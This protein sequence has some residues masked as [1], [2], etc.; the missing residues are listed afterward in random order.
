MKGLPGNG[1]YVYFIGD[2]NGS[3]KIGRTQSHI[4]GRFRDLQNSSP[5]PLVIEALIPARDRGDLAHAE[6]ELHLLFASDRRHGEWFVRSEGVAY[7]IRAIVAT[8]GEQD[9]LG[10]PRVETELRDLAERRAEAEKEWRELTDRWAKRHRKVLEAN[11]LIPASPLPDSS[12]SSG[13]GFDYSAMATV[14]GL[15]ELMGEREARATRGA[16]GEAA[17]WGKAPVQLRVR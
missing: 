2:G 16:L 1:G 4:S 8:W 13:S 7:A 3:V 11:V 14:N 10:R 15:R 17:L 12:A 6:A 5:V 9:H